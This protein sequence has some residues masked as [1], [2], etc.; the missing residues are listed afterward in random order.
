MGSENFIAFISVSG[1][2]TALLF[3]ILNTNNAE[4]FLSL[5]FGISIFFYLFAHLTVSFFV[6]FTEQR[7]DYLMKNDLELIADR[8][9]KETTEKEAKITKPFNV[10]SIYNDL[11]KN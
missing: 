8:L 9:R 11:D 1:F 7:S 10:S 2:F 3:G 6:R 4:E 5:I